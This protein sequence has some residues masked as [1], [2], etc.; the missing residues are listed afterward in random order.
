[1]L[2]QT[3]NEHDISIWIY[4]VQRRMTIK[5]LHIKQDMPIK[6]R[7]FLSG[8]FNRCS[9]EDTPQHE[10]CC[11]APYRMYYNDRPA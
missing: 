5:E 7:N 10:G 6:K 4:F 2:K 8:S 1:M 9:P 11:H 3:T